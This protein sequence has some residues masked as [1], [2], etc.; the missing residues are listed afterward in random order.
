MHPKTQADTFGIIIDGELVVMPGIPSAAAAENCRLRTFATC[1]PNARGTTTWKRSFILLVGKS[2]AA[3]SREHQIRVRF[4]R[5]TNG[6]GPYFQITGETRL[7]HVR[8]TL[9]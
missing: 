9:G 8:P 1:A 7:D 3:A 5:R 2:N 6:P 4:W